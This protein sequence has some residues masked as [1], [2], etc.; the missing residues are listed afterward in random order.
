M[1]QTSVTRTITGIVLAA[2]LLGALFAGGWIFFALI[3]LVSLVAQWEFNALF[4]SGFG[5]YSLVAIL[6]GAALVADAFLHPQ[7]NH[8]VYILAAFFLLIAFFFLVRYGAGREESFS[9]AACALAGIMYVPLILQF[10][11][12]IP[13]LS[14]LPVFLATAAT[15]IGGYYAGS[16]YGRHA[17]WPKVSPKK[18][19]EGSVCGLIA[20][21]AVV[22]VY[23]KA[24]LG[25]P[26]WGWLGLSFLLNLA[27]QAGDFFESALKRTVAV[28]DSGM[29]LPGHGGVLDRID[30]LLFALPVYVIFRALFLAEAPVNLLMNLLPLQ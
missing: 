15:D 27:A 2:A 26:L 17:L 28:K 22:T 23:G 16:K 1:T 21:V 25:G 18:T 8:A 14:L 19:W 5:L 11:L 13:A 29:L 30:S 20:C 12:S 7:A 3:L 10:S 9:P 24:V 4:G 6:C